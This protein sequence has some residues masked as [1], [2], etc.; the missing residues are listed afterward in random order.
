MLGWFT[1]LGIVGL[2]NFSGDLSVIR[3]LDPRYAIGLLFSP[4]NT[5]GLFIL[6]NIFLATTGAEALYS[7]L[8]HVG[9]KNIYASWPYIKICLMLNYLGQAAWLLKVYQDPAYQQIENLNPFFQALPQGWTVFW[10][11]LFCVG[12]NHCLPS[13]TFRIFHVSFGSNQVA[14]VAADADHVSW[15]F[16]RTN[17]YP[18]A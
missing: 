12:C 1:F 2:I 6:G 4:D 15:F 16:H 5:S 10:R 17:V 8:G 7:D 11:R 3:A 14:F 9:K 18:R 13:F